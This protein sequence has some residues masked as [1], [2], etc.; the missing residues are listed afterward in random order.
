VAEEKEIII[1][2]RVLPDREVRSVDFVKIKASL[3]IVYISLAIAAVVLGLSVWFSDSDLRS[4][5]T[6]LISSIAGAALS[7][8]FTSKNQGH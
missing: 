7:Y 2:D 1:S 3:F 4:W 6:G 8:G 5:A